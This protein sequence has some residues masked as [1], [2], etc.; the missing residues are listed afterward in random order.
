MSSGVKSAWRSNRQ[1]GESLKA[2][3]RRWNAAGRAWLACKSRKKG[4]A[5]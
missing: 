1:P 4:V 5:R 2:F 3:A